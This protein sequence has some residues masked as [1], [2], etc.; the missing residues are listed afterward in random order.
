MTS[1]LEKQ[2]VFNLGTRI[3][4]YK[5]TKRFRPDAAGSGGLRKTDWLWRKEENRRA[6]K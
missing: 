4:L 5:S 2:R 1:T 6:E 3:A